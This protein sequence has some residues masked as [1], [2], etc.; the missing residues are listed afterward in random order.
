MRVSLE[1]GKSFHCIH[2]G[3]GFALIFH[4]ANWAI[5][6]CWNGHCFSD[7]AHNSTYL[8]AEPPALVSAAYRAAIVSCGIDTDLS[9][10]ILSIYLCWTWVQCRQ[11]LV[12]EHAL[13]DRKLSVWLTQFNDN[14]KLH[15]YF[16]RYK[17][18]K[19]RQWRGFWFTDL[20]INCG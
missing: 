3:L 4:K 15:W 13:G 12:C 7:N 16:D 11:F 8:E 1:T 17:N 19:I 6:R 20:T 9:W 2:A 5:V 10:Y 14:H 18:R